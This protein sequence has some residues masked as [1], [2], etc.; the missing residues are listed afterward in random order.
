MLLT[1]VIALA[2]ASLYE[3]SKHKKNIQNFSSNTGEIDL[4]W[5]QHIVLAMLI[6]VGGIALFNLIFYQS[7][8]NLFMNLFTYSIVLFTAYHALRQKEIIPIE[9]TELRVM[10]SMDTSESAEESQNKKL[11]SDEKL[12]E[13]KLIIQD[14]IDRDEIYLDNDLNLGKM[15]RMLNVSTHQLSY[16]IN[17]GFKQNF[18]SLINN[19]RI[20]KAKKLLAENKANKYSIVGI[21]Y[22]SGFNSKTSFYNTFKKFTGHSPSEFINPGSD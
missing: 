9:E 5:L 15:A 22:E 4:S 2:F 14:L 18:N 16:V 7:P 17:K 10:L 12:Q 3:I 21:A 19:A 8:L 11:L 6:L 13:L 20:E 1:N